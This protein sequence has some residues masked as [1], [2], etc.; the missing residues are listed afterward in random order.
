MY[1]LKKG[2]HARKIR[3]VKKIGRKNK[4]MMQNSFYKKII[5]EGK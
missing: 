2:T 5:Y 1:A 4:K 3:L